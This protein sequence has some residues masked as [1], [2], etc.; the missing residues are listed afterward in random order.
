MPTGAELAQVG[1]KYL[2]V[3]YSKMDCQAFVERCLADCGIR[4]DLAGSNAW[5]R[6]IMQHG[7]VGTPEACKKKFGSIPVGAFL[8]VWKPVSNKTPEKYRHDG[9][10]DINHIGIYTASGK[11]A[12][13]SSSTKGCVCESSFKG[14]SINGG[15]SRVGLWTE[16]DYGE[17]VNRILRGGDRVEVKYQ[18]KVVGGGLNL[19]E[20]PS[21]SA[22]RLVQIP[23][24]TVI[25]ITEE[26]GEWGRTSYGGKTGWVMLKYLEKIDQ[27]GDMIT[28]PRSEA[29]KI[30]DTLGDWLGLRG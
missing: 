2:G 8:F 26:S 13:N 1:Y 4:K 20:S 23:D 24:G 25:T 11:G 19:R 10:G 3:P 16:I 22:E 7:W 12:I 21:A 27:D 18:A 5:Y 29:E 14:K 30:Y 15:W 6:Y 17:E 28:I 9:I